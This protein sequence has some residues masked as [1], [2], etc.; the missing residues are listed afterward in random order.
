MEQIF[1]CGG[2][3]WSQRDFDRATQSGQ[4]VDRVMLADYSLINRVTT[5]SKPLHYF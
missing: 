3:L 1:Y 2:L 4:L 5:F